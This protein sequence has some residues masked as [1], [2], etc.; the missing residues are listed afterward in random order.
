MS[1][2]REKIM[3]AFVR[4]RKATLALAVGFTLTLGAGGR[5]AVNAAT[6]DGQNT[7][8][9][10]AI[11]E[12]ISQIPRCSKHE[13]RISAWLTEWAKQ[14]NFSV[15]SDDR[16]NVLI[17]VPASKG[18]E[19]RPTVVLQAH[20]DMV[21]QKTD[22]SPHDFSKDPIILVRDGDWLRAQDTTL[23]ADDGIGIATAL[24]LAEGSTTPHPPL[25]LLFTT[26]EIDMTGA[27]GVS[28]EFLTGKK[29]I[30]T[31][32]EIEGVVTL[33][34]A[35]GVKIDI[36]IPLTL[37]ARAKDQ[38]VL[39]MRIDGLLGGIL[40]LKSIRTGLTPLSSSL[41]HFRKLKPSA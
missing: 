25:E 14:R 13:E 41:R 37:S 16:K 39:S 2:F 29:L 15:K 9:I 3:L 1:V 18:L 6:D 38:P 23:G 19:S 27:E 34:A 31:D 22:D 33:G 36:T 5:D 21:C 4:H 7:K 20:M 24:A 35:G 12:E 40:D 26:E 32:S 30:N 8:R 17:S 11:F 28:K 10:L